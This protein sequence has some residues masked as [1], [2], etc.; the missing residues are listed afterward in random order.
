[1]AGAAAG[2]LAAAPGA[3]PAL[4]Q[5][6][7]RWRLQSVWPRDF[8]GLWEGSQKLAEFINRASEGRLSVEVFAATEVVPASATMAAVAKGDLEMGHG[9]PQ[10]WKRLVPACQFIASIPFGLTA[11]EQNAWIQ[12]GGGQELADKVYRQLGCKFFAAGNTGAQA[13]GWFNRKI[14][15]VDDFK[16]LMIRSSGLGGE[17]LEAAGATLVRLPGGEIPQ[18]LRSGRIHAAEWLG[19]YNDLAFKLHES[20]RIYSFPGWQKPAALLDSFINLKA[21]EALPGDLQA[22][23]EAASAG[24]NAYVLNHYLS[25]NAAA[26][27][28]LL[29]EHQ[30]ALEKLPNEVLNHLGSLSGQ[31]IAER[32]AADPLSNEV[33]ASLRTFRA[34]AIPL[35]RIS[36]QAFYNARGLPFRWVE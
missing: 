31:V 18:A 24:V 1:M 27:E 32:A 22:I 9:A 14:T 21:W 30:V 23:V 11:M 17:V 34:S 33:L 3:A 19:P 35:A 13:G 10:Y 12:F 6:L 7:K 36:D 8:P 2:G 20:A 15:S 5:G 4:A 26:L 29:S 25:Q 28:T 16:G